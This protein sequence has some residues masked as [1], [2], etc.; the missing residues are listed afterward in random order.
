MRKVLN[1]FRQLASYGKT[2]FFLI[3]CKFA[4]YSYEFVTIC[5]Q[6]CCYKLILQT[7]E[8]EIKRERDKS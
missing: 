4:L 6:N 3:A 8:L 5:K 7:N 1:T 2:A